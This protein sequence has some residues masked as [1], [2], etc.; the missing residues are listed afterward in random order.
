MWLPS[1]QPALA[2]NIPLQAVVRVDNCS[3]V[4]LSEQ[5]LLMTSARCVDSSLA[6]NSHRV[7]NIPEQGY[8]ARSTAEELPAAP[9]VRVFITHAQQDVTAQMQAGVHA[10]M[11]PQAYYAQL[12]QN[13]QAL[14][15]HCEGSAFSQCQVQAH[16]DGLRYLLVK[17]QALK[18]VR[19]VYVPPSSIAHFGGEPFHWQWPQYAADVALLRVY[20]DKGEPYQVAEPATISTQ[21][22]T[23]L[24]TV[25]VAGYPGHTQRFRTAAEMQWAFTE[26]YP[27]MLE[28]LQAELAILERLERGNTQQAASLRQ[29]VAYLSAQMQQY[30]TAG[31]QQKSEQT[32][33]RLL[34][35]LTSPNQRSEYREAWWHIQQQL[36]ED[37]ARMPQQLWWQFFESLNLPAAALLVY[38]HAQQPSEATLEQLEELAAT[39]D[40][41]VEQEVL[42]YLLTRYQALPE[43][44]RLPSVN[45]FFALDENTTEQSIRAKVAALYQADDVLQTQQRAKWLNMPLGTLVKSNNPWLQFAHSTAQERREMEQQESVSRSRLA[46]ARPQMTAAK[47]DLDRTRGRVIAANANRTLRLSEG[48]IIGYGPDKNPDSYKL[49]VVYLDVFNEQ[50]Q[51]PELEKLP[52]HFRHALNQPENNCFHNPKRRSVL[53]N[54]ISSADAALGSIGSPTFDAQGHVLG[55]VFDFMAESARSEWLYEREQHRVV[56]L[57]VRYLLWILTYY[58]QADT[59]LAELGYQIQRRNGAVRCT[60]N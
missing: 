21:H 34:S 30:E 59:L 46:F 35:W 25:R 16:Q 15:Q 58:E 54:F 11:S 14:I 28:Y 57:D 55:M 18:D 33:E 8:L 13:R 1:E 51:G 31:L 17:E 4:F 32:Q 47:Q 29:H 39:A 53:M 24:D 56:H 19:L 10:G 38:E 5:G 43:H 12:S 37:R 20:N 36:R 23:F 48:Q 44:Q 3:G 42:V 22:Y 7:R 49:P 9:G 45:G 60:A 27:A 41:V 26:Q 52:R 6:W 50:L 40:P 2:R